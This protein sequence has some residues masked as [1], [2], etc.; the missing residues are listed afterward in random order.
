[1][2]ILGID[3]ST[4]M[5]GA[6]VVSSEGL[7]AEYLLRIHNGHSERIIPAVERALADSGIW[8]PDVDAFAVV[9]GPGSFTG[10][11]VGLA[12]VKGFAYSLG[13]PIIPVTAMEALAW[14]FRAYPH[15][16]YPIIDARRSEVFTQP[17]LEGAPVKAASNCKISDLVLELAS[18]SRPVLLV[19]QGALQHRE[20]LAG[21]SMLFFPNG[22][23]CC[24]SSV[25]GLGLHLLGRGENRTGIRC[26]RF[27]CA[28]AAQSINLVQRRGIMDDGLWIDVMNVSDIPGVQVIERHS[29][30]TPWSMRAFVSEIT[31]NDCAHYFVMRNGRQVVGYVGMWL[32][33]DE[34]HIT[35]I[36]VHP[37]WRRRES[38]RGCLRPSP[39][40][41]TAWAPD[42]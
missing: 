8:L 28:K 22:R 14:Q 30:P 1:M 7:A 9:T 32:I 5:G 4:S 17:F 36:A 40:M 19:G 23:Q 2:I 16:I 20:H 41:P 26:C 24:G 21:W 29:F 33:L 11:R 31:E 39:P 13:K 34:G 10:I 35:N 12:T 37:S 42:G 3:T 38:A 25:A 18:H 6:A 15:L 27:I